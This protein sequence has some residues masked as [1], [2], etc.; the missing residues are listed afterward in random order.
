MNNNNEQTEKSTDVQNV[1][2][3]TYSAN[4]IKSHFKSLAQ[5]DDII[6]VYEK[7]IS[8]KNQTIKKL[9][10]KIAELENNES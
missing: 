8:L 2:A 10:E 1:D 7:E 3:R 6:D 4:I 5:L 9:N